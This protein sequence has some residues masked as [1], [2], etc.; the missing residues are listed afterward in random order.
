MYDVGGKLLNGI[1]SIY[2]VSLACVRV[3]EGESERFKFDSGVRQSC[4]MSLWLF[5]VYKDTV[6]KE[7]K[8][9]RGR[10]GENGDYLDSCM[11]ISWFYV[12]SWK[13]N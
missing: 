4:I 3:K 11:Q 1:K 10:M 8:T 9:L 2:F 12:M 6:M 5:S 13:K 7:V